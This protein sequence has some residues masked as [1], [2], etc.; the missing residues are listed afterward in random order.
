M[1]IEAPL[2]YLS[3]VWDWKILDGCFGN[4]RIS[5]TDIDGFVERNG[6][7]L[8]LEAKSPRASVPRGQELTFKALQATNLFAIII[9]WGETNEPERLRV[10]TPTRDIEE[11]ADLDRLRYWVCKWFK[12]AEGI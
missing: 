3:G 8:I 12:W 4:T 10:I 11:S 7:F 2:L 1:S 6:H 5:P 9:V